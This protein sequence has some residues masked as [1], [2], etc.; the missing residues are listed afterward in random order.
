M[1]LIVRN[2]IHFKLFFWCYNDKLVVLYSVQFT[3]TKSNLFIYFRRIRMD[4]FS[5][6]FVEITFDS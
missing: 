3:V 2:L 5:F 4:L 1:A 6:S